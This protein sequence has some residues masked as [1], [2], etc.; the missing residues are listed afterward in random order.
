MLEENLR[1]RFQKAR[2]HSIVLL[3]AR[4]GYVSY[5]LRLHGAASVHVWNAYPLSQSQLRFTLLPL[6]AIWWIW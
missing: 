1:R 4:N 5:A 2:L 6:H 3:D